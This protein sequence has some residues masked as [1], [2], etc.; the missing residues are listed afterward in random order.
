MIELKNL[1]KYYPS[2]LGNQYI[3]NNINFSFPEAAVL[4]YL[5]QWCW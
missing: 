1:T 5:V 2:D 4:L 3:F